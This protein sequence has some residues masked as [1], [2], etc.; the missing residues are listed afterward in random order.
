M[1]VRAVT[2]GAAVVSAV[3]IG[4]PSSANGR[5]R[6]LQHHSGEVPRCYRQALHQ[7][8]RRGTGAGVGRARN[9]AGA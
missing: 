5:Q 6:P 8:V 9:V 3:I 2:A 7:N 1:R 4:T